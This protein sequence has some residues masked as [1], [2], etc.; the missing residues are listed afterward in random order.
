MAWPRQ[1]TG[2]SRRAMG[3]NPHPE[4]RDRLAERILL[5]RSQRLAR[6][7]TATWPSTVERRLEEG[8]EQHGD[9]WAE[10]STA[11]LLDEIS[12]EA[13]DL[14][15]WACLAAQ[16]LITPELDLDTVGTVGEMLTR[17]AA[18]AAEAHSYIVTAKAALGK[19][20]P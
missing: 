18:S 12:A 11:E 7:A 3:G 15:A 19:A 13:I 5:D 20:S 9:S 1:S 10:R 14:A 2:S 16:S 8:Q 4:R 6:L 17:A